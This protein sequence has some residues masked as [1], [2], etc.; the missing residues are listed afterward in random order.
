MQRIA[1]YS[2]D[3][4]GLGRLRR[5]VAIARALAGG[6]PRSILLISGAG[7]PAVLKLP[8][9]A[10]TL[11]LPAVTDDAGGAYGSRCLGIG[12][13]GL[14]RLRSEALRAAL[15]A[16]A[17]DVLVVDRL[18]AGVG[19]ELEPSFELLRDM[20]T[21]L[22]LAL[23][24]VLGDR[25]E[26]RAEWERTGAMDVVRERYDRIWVY[27]DPLVF[28]PA[29]E[30]DMPADVRAM[31]RYSGYLDGFAAPAGAPARERA[32]RGDLDLGDDAVCVCLAGGS[33]EGF[34]L[35]QT[36]AR[37]P[38]PHGTTGVILTGPLMAPEQ[39]APLEALAAARTDLRVVGLLP[40]ADT[41]VWMADHVIAMGGYHTTCEALASARRAL[42]VP[43]GER[44]DQRIRATRLRDI[45]A[46]DMIA[47]GELT[48]LAL[49]AWIAS[50][51]AQPEPLA[52]AI[53]TGGLRR[54]EL[55]LDELR[56][57]VAAP[58][59]QRPAARASA[60]RRRA[61]GA[62]RVAAGLAG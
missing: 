11:A 18:P 10:D 3:A 17:P 41:L 62:P 2:Q 13:D 51:P 50:G 30:Y 19:D 14:V 23:P 38:L 52:R 26:V 24:E 6:E 12:R 53:D 29:D 43:S 44:A 49:A 22:V 47:P 40:D 46:V 60:P 59:R 25:D 32:L 7:E 45:G 21:Q 34:A 4:H 54:L 37:T 48:V 55:L 9:G 20:G 15:A 27:G 57:P 16:F 36:F 5:N 1:L 31:V 8:A 28:D 39:A 58:A 33:D 56:I 42:L 35:A 61:T